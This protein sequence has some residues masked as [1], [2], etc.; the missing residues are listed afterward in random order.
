MAK[1]TREHIVTIQ[2]LN[3]RGQS[4]SQAARTL[5]VS[6]GTVRYHLRRAR[7]RAA[8][9][10]RK[11]S[12]IEQLGLGGAVEHWWDSRAEILDRQID[13]KPIESAATLCTGR[14][15]EGC[16]TLGIAK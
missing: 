1:L 11:P 13:G 5:G 10:R 8:D 15:A 9:G 2:V 7:D 6:E 14:Y 16:K 3:Q 4:Q 12:L